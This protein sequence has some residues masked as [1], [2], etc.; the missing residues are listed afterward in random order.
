MFGI[1]NGR[2]SMATANPRRAWFA[3]RRCKVAIRSELHHQR[4][5]RR[6][7][8][9]RDLDSTRSRSGARRRSIPATGRHPAS[10]SRHGRPRRRL[11]RRSVSCPRGG[12]STSN[13]AERSL[14]AAAQWDGA[15]KR[16]SRGM[17]SRSTSPRS[18]S[19]SRVDDL[20]QE[21][22]AHAGRAARL[23]LSILGESVASV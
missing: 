18:S 13:R 1:A 7:A 5:D 16:R 17:I 8:V 10:S 2:S 14:P 20:L 23:S 6:E 9:R 11:L 3:S 4:G 19:R 12:P 15:A 22:E 21:I